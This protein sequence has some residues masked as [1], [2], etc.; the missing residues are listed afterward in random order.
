MAFQ[1]LYPDSEHIYDL[2]ATPAT[3][4]TLNSAGLAVEFDGVDTKSAITNDEITVFNETN[5]IK[6]VMDNGSVYSANTD[7]NTSARIGADGLLAINETQ[8]TKS[9]MD[10]SGVE[11]T[12]PSGTNRLSSTGVNTKLE[13]TNFQVDNATSSTYINGMS[14][15]F[16]LDAPMSPIVSISSEDGVSIQSGPFQPDELWDISGNGGSAGQYL[17]ASGS[18]GPPVWTTV[19]APGTPNLA[20]VLAEATAGDAE[21]QPI[22]NLSSMGFQ[23]SSG[24]Q[25]A[26]A[27]TA[28]A[29]T[30]ASPA[31]PDYDVI[32]SS[33]GA[34]ATTGRAFQN[35][36]MEVVL[37]GVHYWMPLFI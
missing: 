25:T 37:D 35:K 15:G 10:V 9:Q 22:S 4:A 5:F 21:D 18:G 19:T 36:Y 28:T 8:T 27:I 3:K 12:T 30:S 32:T 20:A 33:Q 26:L 17:L 6:S 31:S 34:D 1:V 14:V 2:S 24:G 16:S 13:C 11:F 23:A 29:S 7:N